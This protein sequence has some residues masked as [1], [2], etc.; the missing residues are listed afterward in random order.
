MTTE[1]IYMMM[2]ILMILLVFYRFSR[3][4]SDQNKGRRSNLRVEIGLLKV[5][6]VVIHLNLD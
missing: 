5:L 4:F 2:G 6:T 3:I 1:L